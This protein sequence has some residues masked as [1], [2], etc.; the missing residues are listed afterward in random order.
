[1]CMQVLLH[2]QDAS[3]RRTH[4]LLPV[5][6]STASAAARA[7]GGTH[8]ALAARSPRTY[9]HVAKLSAAQPNAVAIRLMASQCNSAHRVKVAQSGSIVSAPVPDE[10]TLVQR[11]RKC[12]SVMRVLQQAHCF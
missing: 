6:A 9:L 3:V 7:C 8:S 2:L 4:L 10:A 12:S 1:M 5:L 11:I